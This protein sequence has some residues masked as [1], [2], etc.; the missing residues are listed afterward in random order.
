MGL[1]LY[2]NLTSLIY[3]PNLLLYLIK[4]SFSNK[5]HLHFFPYGKPSTY[6]I[7]LCRTETN[8][9]VKVIPFN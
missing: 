8:L 9:L 6:P 4:L 5:R 1:C 7:S 3:K 2:I